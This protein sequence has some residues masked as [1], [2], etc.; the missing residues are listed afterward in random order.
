VSPPAK[1]TPKGAATRARIV[2]TAAALVL[3]RGVGGTS[4]DDIRSATRT[5]KG[6]LFHYFPGGKVELV[7]ALAA[8]QYERVLAAQRPWIDRL[9]G[10]DAWERWR[11]A[12]LAHYGSQ[13]RWGCPI[14]ALAAELAGRDPQ[15]AVDVA[16]R[17]DDWCAHLRR[18]GERM[19]ANGLLRVDADADALALAIF[20][21]LHGGLLLMQ[22]QQ[23]LAPLRA[24]L[25]GALT[26][27][28]A[29]AA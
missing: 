11:D 20:A 8:L 25:D 10:W 15:R 2:E 19:R 14:G 5:S 6:Q 22:Q 1:L 13:P 9:D 16:A 3:E 21:A 7:H 27:L 26:T 23:S 24:A 17:M 12:L 29:A 28:R 18:G 4:L